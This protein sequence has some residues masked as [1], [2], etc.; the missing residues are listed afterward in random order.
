[1]IEMDLEIQK[2]G[3]AT[4]VKSVVCPAITDRQKRTVFHQVCVSLARVDYPGTG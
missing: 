2:N 4:G 1:M 3:K